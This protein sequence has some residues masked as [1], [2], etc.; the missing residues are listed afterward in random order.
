MHSA[1]TLIVT[2]LINIIQNIPLIDSVLRFVL[3]FPK[4]GITDLIKLSKDS[5]NFSFKFSV[6][7]NF[8]FS[9]DVP[10]KYF[11]GAV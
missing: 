11:P 3:D 8:N 5:F 4:S 6:F 10:L 2:K 1:F 7:F 9:F